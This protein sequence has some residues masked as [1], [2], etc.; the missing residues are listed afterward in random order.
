MKNQAKQKGLP[1]Q[2]RSSE[3]AYRSGTAARLAGLSVETLRVWERRYQL[4]EAGRSE[5]GQRLYTSEQ[6]NRLRLLKN[7]VDQGHGIGLIA[8]LQIAQLE[9][10]ARTHAPDQMHRAGPIRVALVG[11]R[12]KERLA[13]TGHTN[14]SLDIRNNSATLDDAMS[15]LP[16][17]G[18]EVLVVEI[19]E[20]D[21]S[22][23]PLIE[24]ARKVANVRGVVVMYRF[25]ASAVIRQLRMNNCLV[26]RVPTDMSE[27]VGWCRTVLAG[28]RAAL[29]S[30]RGAE[31]GAPQFD[32]AT[33]TGFTTARNS[34]GCEC[35]RHLAEILLMVG[36]FERY[37]AQCASRNEDDALLHQELGRAAGRARGILEEAMARLAQAEGLQY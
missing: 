34:V 20:L 4:S 8:G 30:E 35:P 37:S 11:Q 21:E 31:P 6:V 1:V 2:K 32:D 14:L 23:V 19:A 36:S 12:L 9:E 28:Q 7:L 26:A 10:L 5:S 17:S 13:V 16:D 24:Q 22:A 29:V 15:V 18:A 25:C 33:L 3:S 27:L